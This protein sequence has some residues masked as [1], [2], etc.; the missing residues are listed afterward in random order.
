MV[1]RRVKDRWHNSTP[2]DERRDVLSEKSLDDQAS[3]LAYIIWGKALNGAINL[4]AEDF[5]YDDDRQRIAVMCELLCFQIQLVDRIC[6]DFLADAQRGSL[7]QT[8]CERVG[9]HVQ[10]NLT[11]IAGPGNY[12]PPF[13]E[14]LN[15]RFA[16]Y[17]DFDYQGDAVSYEVYRYLG[18]NVLEIMGEDQTNRWVIDQMIEIDGPDLAEQVAKSVRRLF[19]RASV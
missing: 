10:D 4:H 9:D 15:Q 19:D 3:A 13:V 17:A 8:L 18:A 11:D 5:R 1:I 14:L 2:E 12:R 7:L 6:Y 16:E